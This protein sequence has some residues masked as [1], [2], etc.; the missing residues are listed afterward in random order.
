MPSATTLPRG[1][2]RRPG[3]PRDPRLDSAIL[4]AAA[5]L[6]EERGY[7]GLSLESVAAQAGTTVPAVYRRYRDKD[8]LVQAVID[9]LRFEPLP[10]AQPSARA[11]ALALLQ[12]FQRN[13]CRPRAMS[14]VGSLLAEE[15]RHPRMLERFRETLV[16]PRRRSLAA[17]FQRGLQTGELPAGIDVEA[18]VSMAIGAFYARYVSGESFAPDWADRV[19]ATVWPASA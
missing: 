13:L 14:T 11:E 16:A 6:L 17:A 5:R 4:A 10:A 15:H 7:A 8:E 3:R 19:L 1:S 2:A 9:A 12:S 18:A